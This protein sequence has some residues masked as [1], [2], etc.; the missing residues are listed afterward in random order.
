MH[1]WSFFPSWIGS[2]PA[3]GESV[4][5]PFGEKFAVQHLFGWK[6]PCPRSILWALSVQLWRFRGANR[7]NLPRARS[8]LPQMSLQSRNCSEVIFWLLKLTLQNGARI[9]PPDLATAPRRHLFYCKHEIM[10]EVIS[11]YDDWQTHSHTHANDLQCY[12]G[13]E[14]V[15]FSLLSNKTLKSGSPFPTRWNN[16]STPS[17]TDLYFSN[18]VFLH[19]LQGL[20]S[21]WQR[22]K[23]NF[24]H[25][26][27]WVL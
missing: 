2:P 19:H 16:Y 9:A 24:N 21:E 10:Q 7:R 5:Q 4:M 27:W 14:I 26:W 8:Y 18:W 1:A 20:R 22:Y 12:E 11:H 23:R 3:A 25:A 17:T 13:A 6:L 15:S